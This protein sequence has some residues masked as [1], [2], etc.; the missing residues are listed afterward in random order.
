M[1]SPTRWTRVWANSRSWWWTGKPGVL[2]SLGSQRVGHNWAT[3]QLTY[4]NNGSP[5]PFLGT[6]SNLGICICICIMRQLPLPLCH[7]TCFSSTLRRWTKIPKSLLSVSRS[8]WLSTK[9]ILTVVI[10][11]SALLFNTYYSIHSKLT[12]QCQYKSELHWS[13]LSY[14]FKIWGFQRISLLLLLKEIYRENT[15]L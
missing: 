6:W 9:A 4:V 7:S 14:K 13:I 10:Y 12:L 8:G 5:L 3:E 2:Q 11:M 1:V 15:M